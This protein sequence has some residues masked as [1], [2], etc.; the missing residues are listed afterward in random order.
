MLEPV[1]GINRRIQ[2]HFGFA[3]VSFSPEHSL[4]SFAPR[5]FFPHLLGLERFGGKKVLEIG[6]SHKISM[7]QF[8]VETKADYTNV[9]LES[10]KTKN[11]RVLVSDFMDI[12]GRFDLIITL[13]VFELG[14]IDVNFD[15]LRGSK[16][17]H[18]IRDR[19][20]KLSK[21]TAPGGECVI[22]TISSPCFFDDRSV[23]LAGF[24]LIYRQSP[25]YTFMHGDGADVFEKSDKSELLILHKLG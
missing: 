18:T 7:E 24:T 2:R 20:E 22:G 15:T 11:P 1:L 9:R 25:F 8:F 17:R 12:E 4:A 21:L 14:A 19:I 3:S 5:R 10:N 16:S 23:S 6:G 13:G